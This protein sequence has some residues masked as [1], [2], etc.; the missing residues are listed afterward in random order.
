MPKTISA[1]KLENILKITEE[2]VNSGNL[3][4]LKTKLDN[5]SYIPKVILK[6]FLN[7]TNQ[8]VRNSTKSNYRWRFYCLQSKRNR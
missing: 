8:L 1:K 7:S 6:N 5:N 4:E 3:I 2:Y